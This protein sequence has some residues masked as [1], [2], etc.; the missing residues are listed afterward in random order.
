MS[1]NTLMVVQ[2]THT[3]VRIM[4]T[5]EIR[6]TLLRVNTMEQFKQSTNMGSQVESTNF[7]VFYL[8]LKLPTR[9]TALRS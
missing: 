7:Q 3:K 1:Y 9:V 6:P 4:R 2:H 8:L 5:L